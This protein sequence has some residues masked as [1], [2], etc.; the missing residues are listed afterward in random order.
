M[1]DTSGW[2][3]PDKGRPPA[4]LLVERAR[5]MSDALALRQPDRIPVRFP[6]GYFI[7]DYGGVSHQAVHEDLDLYQ[8]IVEEVA[9]RYGPDSIGGLSGMPGP[10]EALGDRMTKWPGYGLPETGSF[11]FNEHEFMTA[12][13]YEPFLKD[14]S[15]WAVR[16]YLP[17]A[18]EELEGLGN[19]APLGMNLFGWYNL[20]NLGVLATE[21]MVKALEALT[22]A[23]RRL[24]EF[25]A[26]NARSM[27]RLEELGIPPQA[28]RGSLIEAPFDFMSDTLRGMRGIFLD[29]RQRPE[30]LLAAEE[31]ARRIQVEFA[32]QFASKTGLTYASIPLHRGSDGFMSIAQFE[33]FYWPQF[34]EMILELVDAGITPHVYYE[35]VWDQ[36]LEYLAQFPKGKTVG[37]FQNSDIFKVKEVLGDVMC[38]EGGMPVSLIRSGPASAIR[39]RTH[40]VCER[41]G[42]GGGFIMMPSIN[43]FEGCD[44]DLVQV[45][46]DSTKEFGVY[47]V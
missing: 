7:A 2:V 30:Q 4:E 10:S 28:W 3:D 44:P 24:Q 9:V 41:V 46:V 42:H 47:P 29:L 25:G 39:E 36:R 21:P 18:F 32:K 11:Q 23:A 6:G 20:P 26:W 34:K 19:L 17:R 1:T 8:R 31:T 27:A 37:M 15:D 43:E 14:P 40:E 45:W 22:E 16:T 5:R 13:D 33:R 38:I 12:A 35:G